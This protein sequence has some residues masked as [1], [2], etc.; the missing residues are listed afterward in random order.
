MAIRFSISSQSSESAARRGRLETPHGEVE[1][2][3]FM[4]V[5]TK[6]TVKTMTPEELRLVGT[7]MILSNTYHLYLRPGAD[8][9]AAAGGL[10]RF[11]HWEGPI[12]TDSG[13]FQV[14]SLSR[15]NKVDDDGVTFRSHIDGSEH[16][17]TPEK[18]IEIQEQL[19][20]DIIMAFDDVVPYPVAYERAARAVERTTR[21]AYRCC[22][23][24][25][26]QDQALFGIV[27]GSIYPDLRRRSAEELLALDLP[28]YAVGG[29]SVGEPK[30]LFYA[31]LHLTTRLLPWDR[32]RYLMGVGT[33]DFILEAVWNGIDMLD[34]VLPTR[35]ARNGTVFVSGGRLTVRNAAYAR[36]F[37]PLDPTCTCYVCQHYSRAYIRHLLKNNEILGLRL[38]TWHNL[39][40]I[41]QFMAALR[42]AIAADRLGEFR[43]RFWQERG[44]T[45][46][47]YARL[48]RGL[49]SQLAERA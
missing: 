10:H 16:R 48:T 6:G 46:P 15:L 32:P 23:A 36:D 41:H 29:L 47:D 21:W 7:E 22:R 37:G 2:P 3:V 33:P 42:Q 4:P 8:L 24:H 39:H 35:M 26:R 13:G 49:R 25:Q 14:F 5:G 30:D 1:T 12:L 27:Q 17:F 45:P 20:A 28:G 44:A 18:S 19:G 34:C 9:V 31:L 40:F 43:Y 38:T 11:M